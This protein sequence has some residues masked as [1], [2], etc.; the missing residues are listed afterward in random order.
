VGDVEVVAERR[1]RD[2]HRAA[3][4]VELLAR[5]LGTRREVH[6]GED[7][8][9]GGLV[10]EVDA[11]E[12]GAA[13]HVGVVAGQV[14][15]ATVR[16]DGEGVE[17]V[18]HA[19]GGGVG[20]GGGVVSKRQMAAVRGVHGGG[21]GIRAPA[22]GEHLARG[23]DRDPAR[24]GPDVHGGERAVP[25][26]ELAG[27][28]QADPGDAAAHRHAIRPRARAERDPLDGPGGDVEQGEGVFSFAG[29]RH[30]AAVD[31]ERPGVL[32]HR[33][34]RRGPGVRVDRGDVIGL[35]DRDP[36]ELVSQHQRAADRGQRRGGGE[37]GGDGGGVGALG[38]VGAG[39]LDDGLVVAGRGVGVGGR[40]V[41]GGGAVA[42]VP[43]HGDADVVG[44]IEG[45]GL[46]DRHRQIGTGLGDRGGC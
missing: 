16:G 12:V 45:E 40:E 43:Q 6:G 34:D 42:E 25:A 7:G 13:T 8:A 38:A 26:G 32:A 20:V 17:Q 21:V 29:D 33:V 14:E 39:H 15:R 36:Q 11:R 5:R 37:V 10:G 30:R 28:L 22:R 4:L 9:H 24:V 1:G 31:R 35:G 46:A 3:A 18:R 27:A 44:P 19:A 2:G 41:G 23:Q